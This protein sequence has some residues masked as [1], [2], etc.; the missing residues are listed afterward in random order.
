VGIEHVVVNGSMVVD[1]GQHTG[2]RAGR[3]LRKS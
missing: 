3:V 1:G 2:E